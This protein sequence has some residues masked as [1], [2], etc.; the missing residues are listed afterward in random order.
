M[1]LLEFQNRIIKEALLA[2][3]G[4]DKPDSIDLTVADFDG[5]TFHI[6]STGEN[7]SVVQVSISIRC[8]AELQAHGADEYLKKVYG[9]NVA[10]TE[11]GYSFTIALDFDKLPANKDEVINDFA[12]LKRHCLAAPIGKYF[13]L[14]DKGGAGGDKTAVIS[15][16]EDEKI[17]LNAEK[18]RVTVVFSVRF[19]DADDVVLGKVFLAEFVD[20]RK[21]LN[22]APQVLFSKEPP[23]EIAG[24]GASVADNMS[25]V[26]FVLFTRHVKGAERENSISLVQTF[27]DYLHYHIKCSK[28]YLHS[29]MRARV[30]SL[31]KI[32]NRARPEPVVVERKT[33]TGKTFAKK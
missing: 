5:V 31:L 11:N 16:R 21:R 7:K 13:D 33:A 17:Y 26:T 3:V 6:S 1:I 15:Y 18:D 27:R 30:T 32:L 23:R 8:F 25:Y 9:S 12:L 28:A 10:P 2:R 29:R 24:A 14:C 20:A 4:V 19:R 22:Q